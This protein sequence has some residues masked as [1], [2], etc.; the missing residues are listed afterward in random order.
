MV[1]P[2]CSVGFGG[3]VCTILYKYNRP[4]SEKT[5]GGIEMKVAI[6]QCQLKI[7]MKMSLLS[8]S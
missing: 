4:R 2:R 8:G 1:N 6:K 3:F 7:L 5:P